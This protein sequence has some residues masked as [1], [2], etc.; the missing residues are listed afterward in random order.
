VREVASVNVM[1][2]SSGSDQGPDKPMG[3]PP[4]ARTMAV[5]TPS[6]TRVGATIIR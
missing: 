6:I 3:T 1:V 4:G 5:V 2:L